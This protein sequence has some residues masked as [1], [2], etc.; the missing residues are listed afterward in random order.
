[1]LDQTERNQIIEE[2]LGYVRA[3]AVQVKRELSSAL[4]LDELVA[5]GSKGLVEAADRF[6]PT[7]GVAF[8]TFAYYR[9]RGAIFDGLR[10]TGWLRRG[11][12]A[13]FAAAANEYLSN[14]GDR[15]PAAGDPP[16]SAATEL[17]E[18]G[19]TVG[20]LVT[21]FLTSMSSA[22]RED[23]PD[24]SQR[25]AGTRLE[26]QETI[27]VLRRALASLPDKERRI[28]EL[29]YYE[30]QSLV[31]AGRTL[32]LSKSW[33]SRLHARAI[34]LLGEELERLGAL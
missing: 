12:H 7:R 15:Q 1:M 18:L 26:E 33:S 25:D 4:D 5:Y 29:Y 20:D 32:G 31:E 28:L 8:S 14:A 9:I 34:R 21:I 24:T 16:S 19:Q 3:L 23:L 10:Q 6:D 11:D 17:S 30:D 22:T 2:N 27:V 13:R